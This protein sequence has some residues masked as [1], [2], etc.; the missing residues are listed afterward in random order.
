MHCTYCAT[1][2]GQPGQSSSLQG[3]QGLL[4]A[5]GRIICCDCHHT[6]I[7]SEA[8][9]LVVSKHVKHCLGDLG[10]S[11]QW[12]RLPIRLAHQNQI[13]QFGGTPN[14]VGYA[15][16]TILGMHM[17]S[18]ITMLYGMPAALA[19][20]TLAHEAG[21]VWCREQNVRFMPDPAD[22]EGFCNVLACLALQRL[23]E[24]HDAPKRIKAMFQSTD[25]IYGEKFKRQ[26]SIMC[27]L[28]WITYMRRLA[29][30]PFNENYKF[31]KAVQNKA[32]V[33]HKA[34]NPK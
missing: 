29:E 22:E 10:L 9:I 25:P 23:G 18:R 2:I 24:Q 11:I 20:E 34:T 13:L 4:Y 21:H 12:D 7:K 6:A 30:Q 17:D 26:W 5:D 27:K 16:T 19:V 1:N 8:Q 28:G 14:T 32:I 33:N 31:C 3:K 15:E